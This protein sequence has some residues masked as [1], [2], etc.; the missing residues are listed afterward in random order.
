MLDGLD[1]WLGAVLPSGAARIAVW[2]L[3]VGCIS[4]LLYRAIS[5]QRRIADIKSEGVRTRADV[6][7][8]DG[9]FRGVFPLL[10]R[11]IRT[12]FRLLGAVLIPT[13]ISALPVV[14][15]MG[16]QSVTIVAGPPEPGAL[17]ELMP[18][19]AGTELL[20][21]PA[22]AGRCDDPVTAIQW[23]KPG[24]TVEICDTDGRV[25][26]QIQPTRPLVD[27]AR[28][29]WWTALVGSAVTPLPT[30]TRVERITFTPL[31]EKPSAE[32]TWQIFIL[33]VA[34]AALALKLALRIQ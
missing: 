31:G 3:F 22:A 8:Y 12:S 33:A 21:R 19:P 25:L 2:G 15:I 29:D 24:E 6:K 9:D 14:A 32:L 5:P 13:L 20:R 17:V 28:S 34:A 27:A 30:D 18:F 10:L 4:M 16:W 11:N 26:L 7:A 1:A 23:P